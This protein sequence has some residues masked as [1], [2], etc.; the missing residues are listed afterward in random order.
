MKFRMQTRRDVRIYRRNHK[1]SF[2]D[3]ALIPKE[4]VFVEAGLFLM[5][6]NVNLEPNAL[7]TI[8]NFVFELR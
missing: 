5:W 1:R 7:M 3:L 2:A 6:T 8:R 4:P